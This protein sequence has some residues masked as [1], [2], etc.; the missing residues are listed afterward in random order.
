MEIF[1][2][3]VWMLLA[4]VMVRL[5][6]RYA[7]S[8]GAN[9]RTQLVTLAMLVVIFFFVI[10]VTDDLQALQNP[11]ELDCCARRN[12]AA[13]SPHSTYSA[14]AALPPPVFAKPSVEFLCAVLPVS[15]P[16]QT[17]DNPAL[18]PIQNRP[19]PVA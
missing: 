15:F 11:A 2:N 10:S 12:H 6:L 13:F 7:P 1:L 9:R 4:V 16:V 8:Q 3:L 19:P 18:A 17:V 14:V 5:W